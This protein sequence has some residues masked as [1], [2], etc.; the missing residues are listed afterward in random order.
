VKVLLKENQMLDA[1]EY[2]VK[3]SNTYKDELC[4]IYVDKDDDD[5]DIWVY[6]VISEDWYFG[7][8]MATNR[9][10]TKEVNKIKNEIK[11]LIKN[12]FDISIN[13]G[14]YVKKCE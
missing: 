2:Y 13:V 12:V 8:Y 14:S 10:R 1:I 4:D 9:E 5:D 11:N 6:I 7:E 3:N